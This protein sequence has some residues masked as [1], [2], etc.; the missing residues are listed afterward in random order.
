MT[1]DYGSYELISRFY[2][3]RALYLCQQ[4]KLR[5]NW[6][7]NVFTACCQRRNSRPCKYPSSMGLS[8]CKNKRKHLSLLR[9]SQ[10]VSADQWRLMS[11]VINVVAI[12]KETTLLISDS[13]S[14]ISEVLPTIKALNRYIQS[15][16]ETDD[17][18]VQTLMQNLISSVKKR[19]EE[20]FMHE[21][22]LLSTNA[23]PRFNANG[24]PDS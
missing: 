2:R 11:R 19:F 16:C 4:A 8:I 10:L 22:F 14:M 24:F 21:K 7:V 13:K 6:P 20:H 12:F 23:D 9:L 5:I 17:T 15:L 1:R 3:R 18:G